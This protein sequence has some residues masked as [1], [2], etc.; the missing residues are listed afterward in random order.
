MSCIIKVYRNNTLYI[1]YNI[2]IENLEHSNILT[3]A[4]HTSICKHL[5]CAHTMHIGNCELLQAIY[6]VIIFWNITIIMK[7][8]RLIHSICRNAWICINTGTGNTATKNINVQALSLSSS[9]FCLAVSVLFYHIIIQNIICTKVR[10]I[11][12]WFTISIIHTNN[13]N[14]II[15]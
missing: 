6:S 13:M 1:Y 10:K 3:S 11:E 4:F 9:F 15:I 7:W 2:R 5:I 8:V 12:Q 14:N